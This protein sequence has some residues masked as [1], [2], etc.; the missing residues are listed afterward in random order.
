MEVPKLTKAIADAAAPKSARYTIWCGELAGFGL[1]VETTGRRNYV[2]RY[3]A[4]GGGRGALQRQAKISDHGVMSFAEAREAA[5]DVLAEVRRGG[6]PVGSTATKRQAMTMGQL[7]ELYFEDGLIVLKGMRRGEPMKPATA[8]NTKNRLLHHVSPLLG[9]R[10]VAD[11]TPGD[12]VKFAKDVAVGKT[13]TDKKLGPRRR[14]VVRG[15]EGASRKVVR[16]L[17]AVFTFAIQNR[18][19]SENP[20]TCAA[21]RKTDNKRERFLTIDEVKRLG[22]ALNSLEAEG[23][24]SKAANIT[25]LWALTGCRRNEIAGLKWIEVDFASS[26]LR[27]EDSKTGSSIRPL[28]TTAISILKTLRSTA[29]QNDVYVFPA[30]SGEGFYHGVKVLWPTII[31]QAGLPGVSPH[32]LRHTLGSAAASGGEALLLVG[33]ILGHSNARSTQIYAHISHDPAR[34][35]ADRATAG[36]AQALGLVPDEDKSAKPDMDAIIAALQSGRKLPEKLMHALAEFT[37]NRTN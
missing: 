20:V 8:T 3:R 31:K 6:D 37:Q 29:A 25:R 28:S 10:K 7:L 4:D 16:D 26:L 17:S 1:R 9:K 19:M 22:D 21:V 13:A 35:A 27:L 34:M 24:N 18:I 30:E 15:G 23:M 5:R 14:I 2:V 32:T 33:S 36:I 12:I 11:I